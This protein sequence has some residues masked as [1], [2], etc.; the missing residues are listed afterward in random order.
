MKKNSRF[1]A[2]LFLSW[3]SIMSKMNACQHDLPSRANNQQTP[4]FCYCFASTWWHHWRTYGHKPAAWDKS[5]KPW[6]LSLIRSYLSR[7]APST[8]K[9]HMDSIVVRSWHMWSEDQTHAIP[10]G[11][12][13][14]LFSQGTYWESSCHKDGDPFSERP[15]NARWWNPMSKKQ[16]RK[17]ARQMFRRQ[18]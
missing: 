18:D 4:T 13:I 9:R 8:W 15:R 12:T 14:G 6:D 7:F 3:V 2:Q 16:M 5:P 10:L 1:L 11:F 17:G